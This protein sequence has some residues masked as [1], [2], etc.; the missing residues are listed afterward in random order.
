MVAGVNVS[1]LKTLESLGSVRVRGWEGGI[2]KG[3]KHHPLT[4]DEGTQN[5]MLPPPHPLLPALLAPA[6]LRATRFLQ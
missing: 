2:T 5:A 3:R 1:L 6:S 4:P